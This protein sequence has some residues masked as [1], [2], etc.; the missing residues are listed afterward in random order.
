VIDA[1]WVAIVYKAMLFGTTA[2]FGIFRFLIKWYKIDWIGTNWKFHTYGEHGILKS[3]TK[4]MLDGIHAEVVY[5]PRVGDTQQSL[6]GGGKGVEMQIY[7]WLIQPICLRAVAYTKY[8]QSV[9]RGQTL[10][11]YRGTSGSNMTGSSGK[12]PV[13]F[14]L[15]PHC[16]QFWLA[17]YIYL[18]IGQV[19]WEKSE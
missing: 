9:G 2:L 16:T 11:S 6:N 12:I 7:A 5:V 1:R 3:M 13:L 17:T 18:Y 19:D 14:R 10:N 4:I 15:V 8:A